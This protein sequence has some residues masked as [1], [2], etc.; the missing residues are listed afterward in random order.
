MEE[1]LRSK[2]ILIAKEAYKNH[3]KSHDFLH[4]VRVLHT[5]EK[6]AKMYGADLDV[7]R[8]AAI[9]HDVVMYPKNHPKSRFAAQES[10]EKAE[11]IL[12]N[13]EEFPKDKIPRVKEAIATHSAGSKNP[14]KSLEA[15][16]IYDADKLEA[17]GAVAVM[18]VFASSQ[19][20]GRAFYDEK[21]PFAEH[22]E[23][24]E[25]AYALDY[26][27]KLLKV[28]ETLHTEEAR[29]IADRRRKFLIHF[30]EELRAE[31][32]E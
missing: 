19:H 30:L 25:N 16:I 1:R 5:A 29:E 8:A 17:T 3:D 23:M 12:L 18:R 11:E 4:I 10:A 20:I 27:Q 7:V 28:N 26:L 2:L 31:L 13:I 6:L 15:K 14:P 32:S 22:R 24:D 21:D 9:F